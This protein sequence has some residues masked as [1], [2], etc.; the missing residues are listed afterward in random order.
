MLLVEDADRR[1]ELEWC[2]DWYEGVAEKFGL[3]A[4]IGPPG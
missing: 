2:E 4:D 3:D 1:R